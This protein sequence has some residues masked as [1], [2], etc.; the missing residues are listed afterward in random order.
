MASKARSGEVLPYKGKR[1][2]TFRIRYRDA[3]G[4]RVKETLGAERDGWTYQKAEEALEDRKS[5][6][7][8][9]AYRAPDRKETFGPFAEAWLP[10]YAETKGLKRSTRDSYR[11][12]I[13]NRLVPAFGSCRFHES[14][15][16][17]IERQVAKWTKDG[18][19]PQTVNNT[20]NVLSR[21]FKSAR[22]RGLVASNPVELVDRPRVRARERR[23]LTPVEAV[24]VRDAFDRLIGKATGAR[25]EDLH[26][27]RIA[28]LILIDTAIRRGELLGL[29]WSRVALA[30]P[31]GPRIR[32]EET[33][34]RNRFDTPKSAAGRR[35]IEISDVL[36]DALFEWRAVANYKA[37]DALVTAN[38]RTGHAFDIYALGQLYREALVEAEIDDP[39]AL[40]L[41]HALRHSSLTNGAAAG[42]SPVAL[43]A[44]AGHSSFATT[45][46]YLALAGVGWETE[47]AKHSERLW[48]AAK[49]E[50]EKEAPNV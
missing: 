43:Q 29:R 7:R 48:G 44:R 19:G 12:I 40:E 14:D 16:E 33:F 30:D 20:L 22:K 31:G 35:T 26:V 5:D 25:L 10:V 11:T 18:C 9:E 39:G 1:G 21:I 27:A 36:A 34:V 42:M 45:R 8:R 24:R 13:E 50:D 3:S 4:K 15:V 49:V 23:V 28:F 47:T 6:V 46:G 41:F 2:T 38:Q 17:K 32:V 37:D